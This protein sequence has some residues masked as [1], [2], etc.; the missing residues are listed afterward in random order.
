M[1]TLEADFP[2]QPVSFFCQMPAT[3]D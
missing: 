3:P 2:K 1:I